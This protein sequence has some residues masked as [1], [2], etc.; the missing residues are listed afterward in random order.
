MPKENLNLHKNHRLRLKTRFLKEGLEN[1][2]PHN[3]LELLLFYAIPQNDTNDLAHILL[4]HFGSITGVFNAPFDE[5]IKIKGVGHHTATMIKLIPELFSVYLKDKTDINSR[6]S[7]TVDDVAKYLVPI[8]VTCET[9]VVHALYFD[10]RMNLIEDRIVFKGDVNSARLSYK[11]IAKFALTR[12]LPNVI[13]AHNHPNGTPLPSTEDNR[14]TVTLRDTL[15]MF[16]INLVEH[17][18][19]AGQK[20]T[21]IIEFMEK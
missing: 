3:V 7:Y 4:N 11:D 1:F 5:L 20:Y 9:E 6:K 13:V 17:L 19:I 16:N 21:K 15:R 14:T 12:D 8:Y 10:N 2:E 18:L